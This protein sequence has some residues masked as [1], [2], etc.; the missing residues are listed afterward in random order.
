MNKVLSCVLVGACLALPL[1]AVPLG[2]RMA[3]FL[4]DDYG[5]AD[6]DAVTLGADSAD[7]GDVTIEGGQTLVL[8]NGLATAW[9]VAFAG[10]ARVALAHLPADG[11]ILTLRDGDIWEAPL[12]LTVG[13][14]AVAG[15]ALCSETNGLYVRAAD[16]FRAAGGDYATF[17][18]ARAAA[19]DGGRVELLRDVAESV[20]ADLDAD[21]ELDLGGHALSFASTWAVNVGDR[22]LTVVNG[23]IACADCGFYVRDG[24]LELAACAVT[25]ARR[26]AQVRGAGR[27]AV[28]ADARLETTG[29]DPVIFAI[30]G[31]TGAARVDSRGVLVQS[32]TA[33]EATTAYDIAGHPDDTFG[34]DFTLDGRSGIAFTRAADA[35]VHHPDGQGGRV[36]ISGGWFAL[37]PLAEQLAAHFGVTP[38]TLAAFGDGGRVVFKGFFMRIR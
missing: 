1:G 28:A 36:R 32:F 33:G 14:A 35:C 37:P 15:Y 20:R 16:A 25:A 10:A 11:K 21:L 34:A 3:A 30:G 6:G 29:E 19:G 26:V 23:R 2:A 12:T 17:R 24:S 8:T 13:G 31:L 7:V 5:E 18:A 22:S 4:D 38:E 9:S 27:V